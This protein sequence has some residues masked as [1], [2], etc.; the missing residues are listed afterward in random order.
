MRFTKWTVAAVAASM[1]LAGSVFAAERG[2][3]DEAKVLVEKAAAHMAAVGPEKAF[4]DFNDANGG[5]QDRDLFVFAYALD[6][7]IVCVPG[8]PALVGR[9]AA[10][11]KDVDG[12]E[13]GK[14][15]MAAA[16]GGGGWS[17][18]RMANPATKKT[19]PKKTYSV[20][21][22]EYVIGSGAYVP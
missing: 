5:Y 11:L 15:V 18:Y 1:L 17:E 3:P 4:A 16:I 9:N 6:G 8:I 13:F 12:K 10:I 7:K 21:V 20:K 14:M 22:G 19:E 2:T